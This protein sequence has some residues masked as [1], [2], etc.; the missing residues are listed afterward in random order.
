M[1]KVMF[2]FNNIVGTI[3]EGARYI[4]HQGDYK[5]KSGVILDSRIGNSKVYKTKRK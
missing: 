3:Y 4:I 1:G 5:I 2:Y